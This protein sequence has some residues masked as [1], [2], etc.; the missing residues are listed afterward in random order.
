M[1]FG[2]LQNGS[3]AGLFRETINSNFQRCELVENKIN[4]ITSNPS[5]SKYV[6]EKAVSD[7]ASKIYYG[8]SA[9]IS[10]HG[11]L[12]FI[13]DVSLG[14][15]CGKFK[16]NNGS[17][18]EFFPDRARADTRTASS[19][20]S[21]NPVLVNGEI[22]VEKDTR[23][24]KIG[25]GYSHWNSLSYID[26]T[27]NDTLP[28]EPTPINSDFEDIYFT[29]S[30]VGSN[31]LRITS[32][33]LMYSSLIYF[34]KN[35]SEHYRYIT[36]GDDGA[37]T[38]LTMY[39]QIGD[40]RLIPIGHYTRID[41]LYASNQPYNIPLTRTER[42]FKVTEI[43]QFGDTEQYLNINCNGSNYGIYYTVSDRKF[44]TNICD[45]TLSATETINKIR[46]K[47]F[48]WKDS[49]SHQ[50]FGFIAQEIEED[51]GEQYVAK[52]EQPDGSVNYQMKNHVFVP[53]IIKGLQ[54]L[55]NKLVS[56]L[57]EIK[58]QLNSI[59][60]SEENK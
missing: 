49:L 6:T 26:G 38:A 31:G 51:I 60:I 57:E 46:I 19:W 23:K 50:D 7:Y 34:S 53:L 14:G 42:S 12:V 44:K 45:S 17:L 3:S 11:D 13:Y 8:S 1:S 56:E 37:G 35:T 24:I 54:D 15:N 20:A 40:I 41:N 28:V 33:G 25:D 30:I 47:Q 4:A 29:G 39:N 52:I 55:N 21:S 9:P 36:Y 10:T 5:S 18:V 16:Y 22:G 43:S 48:D 32:N 58:D 27:T 59:K 2:V